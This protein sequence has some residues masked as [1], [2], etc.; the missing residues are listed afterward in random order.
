[1]ADRKRE[2]KGG[3]K[4]AASKLKAEARGAAASVGAPF[5]PPFGGAGEISPPPVP[6][7]EITDGSGTRIVTRQEQPLHPSPA[8]DDPGVVDPAAQARIQG[9]F[10]YGARVM[11]DAGRERRRGV[12]DRPS[13]IGTPSGDNSGNLVQGGYKLF[14]QSRRVFLY[15]PLDQPLGD[16]S[17]DRHSE[18]LRAVDQCLENAANIGPG[19]SDYGASHPAPLPFRTRADFFQAAQNDPRPPSMGPAADFEAPFRVARR[20]PRCPSVSP[21]R[22]SPG[23]PRVSR[24]RGGDNN[25]NG[26]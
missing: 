1:M 5:G 13:V 16:P 23:G 10:G 18:R 4:S 25:N 19:F 12:D 24:S 26:L 9:V 2:R 14:D 11:I 15:L 8:L 20:D 21:P 3:R 17:T 6:E 7:G 22:N